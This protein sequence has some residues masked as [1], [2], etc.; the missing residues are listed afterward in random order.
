[1]Q[2]FA[3]PYRTLDQT[4]GTG[5]PRRRYRR[6]AP[7]A[8][9]FSW[10]RA[11]PRAGDGGCRSLDEFEYRPTVGIGNGYWSAG[12]MAITWRTI[13]VA[14]RRTRLLHDRRRSS[15][16]PTCLGWPRVFLYGSCSAHVATFVAKLADVAPD[17]SSVLIV[18]GS[19]NATRRDS[20]TDPEPLEP[21][22]VYELE[23]PMEP[24]GWVS[25]SGA[26]SPAGGLGLRFPEPLAHA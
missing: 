4:P 14:T 6:R 25:S 26:S 15:A 12:G 9:S 22:E 24:T 21:G 3:T 8:S 17:G 20:L 2:E 23:I 13:N 1:M 19:L 18:D 10:G 7:P 16:R 5:G 11:R